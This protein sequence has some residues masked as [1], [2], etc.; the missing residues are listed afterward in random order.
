[1]LGNPGSPGH[2]GPKGEPGESISAPKMI[3][4]PA[5]LTVTE[6]QNAIFYC[7]ASGNPKPKISWRKLNGSE[8]L[9]IN[10]S[11]LEIKNVT[12]KDSGW[13]VC[14][15]TNVLGRDKKVVKLLVEGEILKLIFRHQAYLRLTVLFIYTRVKSWRANIVR[16][17]SAKYGLNRYRS[18]KSVKFGTEFP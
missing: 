2:P 15:A 1:M 12:Y 18:D 9:N 6:N 14:K 13:Y 17:L 4:S 11:K 5:S 3:V 16:S 8:W 7:S 10:G